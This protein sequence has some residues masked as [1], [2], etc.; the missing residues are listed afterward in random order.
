MPDR[1]REAI[2][3]ASRTVRLSAWTAA[4]QARRHPDLAP[5]DYARAGRILDT[6]EM[7]MEGTDRAMG[8]LEED[9]RPWRAVVKAT[10]DGSETYLVTLHKARPYDLR[11]ARRRLKRIDREGG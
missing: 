1:V 10:A 2:G 7:F 9:G 4:K 3:G 8:F 6:G 5:G 11:A